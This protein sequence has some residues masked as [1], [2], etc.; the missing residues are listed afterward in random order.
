MKGT[1]G[2]FL[3]KR[4][5]LSPHITRKKKPK[6]MFDLVYK[7]GF[8]LCTYECRRPRWWNTKLL[9]TKRLI[10]K[11]VIL[12]ELQLSSI[13]IKMLQVCQSKGKINGALRCRYFVIFTWL[14]KP[15]VNKVHVII[16]IF[17]IP[18]LV[19]WALWSLD[20]IKMCL[21]WSLMQNDSFVEYVCCRMD[22]EAQ[23][24]IPDLIW[25]PGA[26]IHL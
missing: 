10:K 4:W 5:D 8:N 21:W 19:A 22:D 26:T 20:Q 14:Q 15:I 18:F 17:R 7:K 9:V 1:K 6:F 3:G 25:V 16:K 11:T 2:F 12:F 24:F 13:L 23:N